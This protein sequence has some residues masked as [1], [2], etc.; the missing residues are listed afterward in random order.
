MCPH[1]ATSPHTSLCHLSDWF[2]SDLGSRLIEEQLAVVSSSARRFHGDALLW[3]GCQS[4]LVDTVRGC[5]IRHHFQMLEPGF[6]EA[7]PAAKEGLDI[8][9][10][11]AT[12]EEIPLANGVLDAMVLH[13]ALEASQ[14]PRTAIRECARV[15]TGGG[16]LVVCAFNPLSLWGVR[17]LYGRARTDWTSDLKFV[18]PH[19]LLDWLAVLGFEVEPVKYVAYNLPIERAASEAALWRGARKLLSERQVPLGGAYVLTAVK[20]ALASG[21]EQ[22]PRRIPAGKLAPVAYPKLTA[23]ERLD[24]T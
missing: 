24:T 18:N 17:A 19:R 16:R 7:E 4:P 11:R 6:P 9:C 15:L 1:L 10:F 20:K 21:S 3:V 13:H 12:A 5:M 23:S 2:Q 14:D 22:R 8:A